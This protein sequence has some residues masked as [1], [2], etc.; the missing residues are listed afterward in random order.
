[1]SD[2]TSPAAPEAKTLRVY[3]KSTRRSFTHGKFVLAPSSFL[4]VPEELGKNWLD[5]YPNEIVDAGVA[6]KE[7]GG[8]QAEITALKARVAE[9]ETENAALKAKG[10]KKSKAD[11][12][13]V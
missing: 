7:I 1:M 8:A 12:D 4:T 13:L 10:S 9:L 11:S 5:G 3:N 2:E 6:Q